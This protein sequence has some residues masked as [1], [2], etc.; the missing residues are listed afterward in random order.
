[1]KKEPAKK[2]TGKGYLTGDVG[3]I[4]D[5]GSLFV[6]ARRTDLI[7]TGGENVNPLEVEN[8]LNKMPGIAE[9]C[10]FAMPD[11]EWG[12]LVAAAVVLEINV[13]IKDIIEFLREK[14]AGYK[15]PK[16]FY[17]VESIPRSPLGKILREKVKEECEILNG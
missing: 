15:I 17:P 2:L 16:R 11:K 14:I 12:Q 8:A 4:D 13:S 10:V 1:M 5:E 6:E 3:Y 7:I 9:S